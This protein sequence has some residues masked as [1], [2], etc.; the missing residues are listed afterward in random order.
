MNDDLKQK[1]IDEYYIKINQDVENALIFAN[2]CRKKGPDYINEVEMKLAPDVAGRVEGIVGPK[3]IASKIRE[4]EEKY[5][6][7]EIV[8]FEI[9]KQIGLGEIETG[10]ELEERIEQAVRTGLAIYTEGVLVAPTEGISSVKLK[11]NINKTKYIEI[12]FAGP[13]RSAGGTAAAV[14]VLLA[15]YLRKHLNL[16]E[17]NADEKELDRYVEEINLYNRITRLQ[18]LPKDEDVK[19]IFKNC[20]ICINGDPTESEEV[21]V[22]RDLPRMKTNRVRS[23]VALVSCEGIALKARKVVKFGKKFELDWDWL[24]ATIKEKKSDSGAVE[25]KP[26]P[27]FM[28]GDVAGRPIFSFPSAKGGWRLRYGRTRITGIASKAI[29]P[30]CMVL[31]DEFTALGTQLRIERPGKGA[32]VTPCDSIMAPIVRLKCGDVISVTSSEMAHSI[33]D[34]VERILFLGDMLIT[35]GDFSKANHMLLPSPFVEEYWDLIAQ[36]NNLNEKP[37]TAREAFDLCSKYNVPLHPDYLYFW[38]DISVGKIKKLV[39]VIMKSKIEFDWFDFK[40]IQI[41]LCDEKEI[42]EE[43]GILHK[44]FDGKISIDKEISYSLLRTLG[45][46]DSK[47]NISR[48]KFDEN[49]SKLNE[50]Q[51]KETCE[52]L[53]ELSGVEIRKKSTFYIGARMGRPEKASERPNVHGLFPISNLGGKIKSV[54]NVVKSPYSNAVNVDILTLTCQKCGSESFSPTCPACGTRIN[55]SIDKL[56]HNVRPV[57]F[58]ELYDITCKKCNYSPDKF[59]SVEKLNNYGRIP[60]PLEKGLM[61]AKHNVNVFRDGTCR[62]DSTDAPITHFKPSEI[63]VSVERLRELGYKYDS[64]GN[65]LISENQIVEMF[66][67]DVI[68][69]DNAIPFFMKVANFVDDLLIYSYGAKPFYKVKSKEDLIGHQVITL[70]PHTSA[71]VLGRLIGFVRGRVNFSHPYVICARRRNAD[72]DEDGIM[73]LMDAFINFSKMYLPESRGGTMDSSLVLTTKVNPTEI[74]D[75]VHV[76]EIVENYDIDFYELCEKYE[77]PSKANVLI[78]EKMLN[79]PEVYYNVN[80]THEISDINDVPVFTTYVKL[81]T[82]KE[83]I[84]KQFSLN[85]KIRAVDVKEAVVILLNSHFI[86][87]I[88]GNLRAFT[89]QSIRCVS[90][91]NSYRRVPLVGKCEKCGGKLLLTINKGGIEK[92]INPT[93]ELV[94]KYKLPDYALQRLVLVRSELSSIF[95]DETHKQSS[96]S[97]FM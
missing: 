32:I 15:D 58:K 20:K 92:Y 87:D 33:K 81:K 24:K 17:Y 21:S 72:G 63:G 76:M 23:G 35:Y 48:N 89:R 55:F 69:S 71:G 19:L 90:C 27:S 40:G 61:R 3:G 7:R 96:L 1:C 62:F 12:N 70:A 42:L 60:E 51:M 93:E 68:I 6:N 41:D 77:M 78:V 36:K 22:Y 16:G 50:N 13:I 84:E 80:Y 11:D 44:V 52:F 73:L 47:N 45:L 65:E 18:Y 59:K 39:D 97:Q 56:E 95:E 67:Q 38:S 25:V 94:R 5:G 79:K 86:P 14:T 74:D 75:E 28:D 54:T 83:K 2:Q 66:P 8:A 64:K 34:N 31:L 49:Y 53:T 10:L 88:Y 9:T 91:N 43:L 30:A 29:H 57:N 85:E 46:I 37:T 82:M 4:L 26:N